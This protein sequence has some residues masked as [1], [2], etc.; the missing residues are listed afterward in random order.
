MRISVFCLFL[1]CF[2]PITPVQAAGEGDTLRQ[3]AKTAKIRIGYREAE[4]PF[5]YQLPDGEV[6]GFSTDLCRAIS[7]DI[8]TQ[9]E[10][11]QTRH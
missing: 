3:I 1:T 5:S 2:I 9:S 11:G 4:P 10:A 7:E 6:T 8:R